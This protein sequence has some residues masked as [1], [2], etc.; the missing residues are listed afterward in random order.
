MN[1]TGSSTG[2]TGNHHQN[3]QQHPMFSLEEDDFLNGSM[4][5][6]D[7][8]ECPSKE[9]TANHVRPRLK[10]LTGSEQDDP[11]FPEEEIP[12]PPSLMA[13]PPPPDTKNNL[14]SLLATLT[15]EEEEISS[16]LFG[17]EDDDEEEQPPPDAPSSS[18]PAASLYYSTLDGIDPLTASSSSSIYRTSVLSQHEEDPLTPTLFS[19]LIPPTPASTPISSPKPKALPNKLWSPAGGSRNYSA[20]LP[21]LPNPHAGLHIPSSAARSTINHVAALQVGEII[22]LPEEEEEEVPQPFFSSVTVTNPTLVVKDSLFGFNLLP[23]ASYW[24]YTVTSIE[25]SSNHKQSVVL[26]RFRHFVALEDRLRQSCPGAILPPRPE[27]H[28]ELNNSNSQDQHQFAL[29]RC[30]ELTTYLNALI[31]HPIAGSS[32]TLQFFLKFSSNDI[33]TAWPEVSGNTFTRLTTGVLPKTWD[34]ILGGVVATTTAPHNNTNY[35]MTS[36]SPSFHNANSGYPTNTSSMIFDGASESMWVGGPT[37]SSVEAPQYYSPTN[38]S[39]TYS[40]ASPTEENAQILTLQN[41]ENMRLIHVCQAVPKL[42]GAVTLLF[43]HKEYMGSAAME[44]SKLSR[45]ISK[46]DKPLSQCLEIASTAML[47]SSRRKHKFNND[48]RATIHPFDS[49]LKLVRMERG[50]LQDRRIALLQRH[51]L[52]QQAD[53]KANKLLAYQGMAPAGSNIVYEGGKVILLDQLEVE[54][55]QSD[56][57]AVE[58]MRHAEKVGKVLQ[59][60]VA[61]LKAIRHKEWMSTLKVIAHQM[62]AAHKDQT[63][64]WEGARKQLLLLS[65]SSKSNNVVSDPILK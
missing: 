28:V 8:S 11:L 60:E 51:A 54:A 25:S 9:E 56:N 65:N 35:S 59:S 52:R 22:S 26:R 33:G 6:L 18:S 27:K 39:T 41:V 61:R 42:E 46:L 36:S 58:A 7:L 4:E 47:K 2:S 17:I 38:V 64:I 19:V 13:P 53:A 30:K 43:Q 12:P 29:F 1:S 44:I 37:S 34:T 10:E 31:Q 14:K 16:N 40:S 55:T 63:A 49:E 50:A 62:Q 5:E 20:N 24:L 21:S 3:H 57:I 23:Q 32:D 48:L 45:D 15:S